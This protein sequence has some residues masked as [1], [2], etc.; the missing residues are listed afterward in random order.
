ML[1]ECIVILNAPQSVITVTAALSQMCCFLGRDVPPHS[2]SVSEP[3]IQNGPG[4][5]SAKY[6]PQLDLRIR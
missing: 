3:E 1:A 5:L 2:A 4:R 6:D